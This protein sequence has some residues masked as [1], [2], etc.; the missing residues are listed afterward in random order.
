[1]R[2]SFTLRSLL[3]IAVLTVF[4]S[5][6][7]TDKQS[8]QNDSIEDFS[9]IKK[10]PGQFMQVHHMI[11]TLDGQ[12]SPAYKAGDRLKE[13][14]KAR[15][16]ASRKSKE[17]YDWI[18]RGPSNSGGR[19]R[20][21]VVDPADS[22]NRTWL[23]GSVGGGI[24]RT[25]DAG[26]TWDQLTTDF[27]SLATSTI[28]MAESNQD[29]LYVGTGEGFGNI[30]G[31]I[32]SGI[33]KSTD[34]GE[35]WTLL[36]STAINEFENV[37]RLVV[38]PDKED[39]V[40]ACTRSTNEFGTL[41]THIFKSSD[42][43]ETWEIKYQRSNAVVQQL[44]IAPND[45]NVIYATVRGQGVFQSLD[46]GETWE[47]VWS[48]DEGERRIEM[49]ISPKDDGVI[50]LSCEINDGSRLYFTRDTFNTVIRP[51]YNGRQPDWLVNQGWYDNT[52]AVHPYNDSI[53]WVAGQGP[54]LEMKIGAEV[55]TITTFD[56][57]NSL[58]SF[59]TPIENS[60]FNDEPAGL[61]TSLFEGLPLFTETSDEDIL[62][63]ELRFGD[64]ASSKAHLI[65]VDIA[66]FGF[67]FV[68]MVD[69]PFEAWDAVNNR[70]IA[71]TLFDVDGNGEWTFEDYSGQTDAFHDVVVTNNIDYSETPDPTIANSNPVFKAQYYIFMGRSPSYTGPSDDLPFGF[72][73]FNTAEETGLISE[74]TPVVD[75]YFA[76]TEI[77]TVGTKGV[78]VDHH[79]IILI[80]K[81]TVEETFYVIN[82]NDG[83]VAFSEDS[84][85]TFTQT[86][87]SF[88][89]G[90]FVSLYGYNVSQFYGIDK[91]NG[92]NRYIGGTQDNGT[93]VSPIDPDSTSIWIGAP[94]GDG[95][96]A[97][98]HYDNPNLVLETSQR[99]NLY[100][101]YDDGASWRRVD[102]PESDGPFIT[103]LASS[104][105]R[106]DL[107]FMVSSA[108]VLRS[109]DFAEN[110][111]VIEMP[112]L[113]QYQS[114]WGPPIT[115]SLAD[116]DYVW[117]GNRIAGDS[118][119]CYSTDAGLTF[120][121]C[122]AYNDAET[123]QITGIATHPFD[124]NTAYV[125]SSQ[126][127]A[128]K[129]LM[130]NDLGET[131]TDLSGYGPGSESEGF[132]DVAVYSLLVMPWDD[133]MMWAGTEIGIFESLDG[134]L[135]WEYA[136]NGFPAVSI[137]QMKIVNDEIVIAT[138][139]RGVWTLNTAPFDMTSVS[140]AD[141][142]DGSAR[143]YP[144]P[145]IANVN[146][147]YTINDAQ[148]VRISL[149]SIEGRELRTLFQGSRSIGEYNLNFDITDL[150]SGIYF[151]HITGE[152]GRLVEKLVVN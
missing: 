39:E 99:N 149:V 110:W 59:I 53:V 63:V 7:S 61:A 97:A 136:N 40:L 41:R 62:N 3:F 31:I 151:V 74:F 65:S 1:M 58:A 13:Y 130:T 6:N 111:E 83:G 80:P 10:G 35:T 20:G 64:G 22:T 139:G 100:K 43:G 85:E 106:P 51:I 132:P 33:W 113:W 143:L 152:R 112:A 145:A 71:M 118:R 128:P 2:T 36:E 67:E 133:N 122:R 4:A 98:W 115:I 55:G 141:R 135:T 104:Q 48:A 86:G 123:G 69:V 29:V 147:D 15:A 47:S 16:L 146:L 124:P 77:A 52:I 73:F 56:G 11:R 116:P 18:D 126:K 38:S 27:S 24:W 90:S 92:E 30:D 109:E 114:S 107:V 78:H 108:G 19:T 14:R 134:G 121:V 5:C 42:G 34:R 82:T 94:S 46:R 101:S 44:V 23:L 84:G 142:L 28:A 88:N 117:T 54:M 12:S 137:W 49:A 129:I 150:N 37:T 138:H 32:G 93:W 103:R 68:E 70:Q 17:T 81:D 105:I 45:P 26:Q 8:A 120:E 102:L 21:I 95:F 9:Q 119:I 148:S 131:W 127:S 144:N 60:S 79:G 96:E 66:T 50:Y 89:D 91:R 140:N 25:T 75:G 76:Y 125:L 87:D 72:I 57:Y